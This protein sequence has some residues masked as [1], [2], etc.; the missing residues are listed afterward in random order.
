MKVLLVSHA[1]E[2][3]SM[4]FYT[5]NTPYSLGLGY[6]ASF[7]EQQG[8]SVK[9]LWK[10][11][12][13]FSDAHKQIMDTIQDWNPDVLGVQMF[14]MNRVSSYRLI[15]E[16]TKKFSETRIVVG[17][18][19]ASAMPEQIIGKHPNIIISVGEGEHTFSELLDYFS[20]GMPALDKIDGIVFCQK[21][22]IVR[23]K[24]RVLIEDLDSLPNPKH[25]VFFDEEPNRTM[26]HIVTTRGCPFMCSFCCLHIISHRQFRKR[27]IEDVVREIVDLKKKYPRLQRVQIHDDIFTL[28]NER[29]IKFCK[30]II[31]ESL[32]LR[33]I[34]SA[35]VKPV[36]EEMFEWMEKAGFEK[37]MFGVETGSAMLM[38]SI[39][40]GIDKDDV[41]KLFLMLKKFKFLVT[42]FLI[43][44]FPGETEET[45]NETIDFVKK[46]QKIRYSYIV[47]V[48][49]L[50]V[51]PGTAVYEIMKQRGVISDD[52]W[53]TD[54]D[55]PYCT[56][57][58]DLE[59][60]THFENKMLDHLS[61]DR[62]FSWNGFRYHFLSMPGVIIRFFWQHPSVLKSLIANNIKNRWPRFYGKLY[63]MIKG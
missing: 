49:K 54:Q 56:I 34:V 57:E 2:Q 27:D 3:N 40:K 1:F 6:L 24:D 20:K 8:H 33:F 45:V 44:G 59:A 63:L 35:K 43:V 47:G 36:S 32:G 31:K 61:I 4:D 19:H 29:V 10:D 5:P 13:S 58:H 26:A 23:T 52:Y 21:G 53:M 28:D 51:Y 17:G 39:K 42:T 12:F 30:L 50:W 18:I 14:T 41:V 22:K 60:L 55:V 37:V 16:C 11:G 38:D 48:G 25:E 9:I 62:I 7:L 46:L 15:E